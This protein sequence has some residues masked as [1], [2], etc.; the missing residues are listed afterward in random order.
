MR[1]ELQD[2]AVATQGQR[3]GVQGPALSACKQGLQGS[4]TGA[5]CKGHLWYVDCACHHRLPFLFERSAE[6]GI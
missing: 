5:P 6:V 1:C 3:R 4:S 2:E